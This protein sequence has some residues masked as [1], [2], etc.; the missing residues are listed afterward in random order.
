MKSQTNSNQV[1]TKIFFYEF[2]R[3]VLHKYYL[4]LFLIC[5]CYGW[6]ILRTETILGISH[7]AP[8]SGWSF[9]AYLTHSVPLTLLV[10]YFFLYQFHYGSDCRV[11]VLISATE[12]SPQY[13][14]LMRCS[15]I[16]AAVLLLV[17]FI[18]IEGIGFLWALF[19]SSISFGELLLTVLFVFLPV[20]SLSFGLGLCSI[21]IHP[22]FFFGSA[23]L[24]LLLE[25]LADFLLQNSLLPSFLSM[26]FFSLSGR[27]FFTNYPL[28]MAN[29][30]DPFCVTRGI[31]MIRSFYIL[32][33][34]GCI[35]GGIWKNRISGVL[36][37]NFNSS[38]I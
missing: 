38:V 22:V 14:L 35:I 10:V 11:R 19:P 26:E 32:L 1:F 34:S 25:P 16:L 5:A 18:A 20:L 24:L 3:I 30:D 27:T 23:F 36:S 12:V 33:G 6:I 31:V 37:K 9:G 2:R 7:T 15:A 4:G 17:V 21:R 28:T 13:Y 29:A 8:F